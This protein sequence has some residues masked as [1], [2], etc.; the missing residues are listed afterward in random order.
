MMIK[1]VDENNKQIKLKIK[2]SKYPELTYDILSQETKDALE[3][4]H[5]IAISGRPHFKDL[6]S[7][8]KEVLSDD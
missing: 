3:E 4:A 2:E 5:Q 6:D 7:F 8:W 1:R